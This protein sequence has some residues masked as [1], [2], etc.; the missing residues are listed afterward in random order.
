MK[1]ITQILRI[2]FVNF[3]MTFDKMIYNQFIAGMVF[4]N[5][6]IYLILTFPLPVTMKVLLIII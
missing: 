2:H 5:C 3:K 4:A 6:I 1:E